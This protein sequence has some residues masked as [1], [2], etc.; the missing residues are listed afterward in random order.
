M[1]YR[2]PHSDSDHRFSYFP[3]IESRLDQRVQSGQPAARCSSRDHRRQRGA[4]IGRIARR[5]RQ[6]TSGRRVHLILENEENQASRRLFR[7]ADGEPR[8]F[9]PQWNDDVH[10]VLHAAARGETAGY[11]ADYAGDT[12]P[13]RRN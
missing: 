10:D 3:L 2:Y 6:S 7:I 4:C 9:T 11:Y 1:A 13:S 12:A 8:Q 5:I